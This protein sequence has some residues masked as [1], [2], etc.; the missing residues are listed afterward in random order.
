MVT[1]D[2]LI[3]YPNAYTAAVFPP[4]RSCV[5]SGSSSVSQF[6]SLCA[7]ISKCTFSMRIALKSSREVGVDLS[8]SDFTQAQIWGNAADKEKHRPPIQW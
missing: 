8:P 1:Y 6:V 2:D 7:Y 5:V 4:R 3:S